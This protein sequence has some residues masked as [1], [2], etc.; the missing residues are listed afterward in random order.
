V[1]VLLD[2]QLLLWAAAKSRRIPK[3]ARQILESRANEIYF[4]AASIWEIA[5]KL[6][7]RRRDFDVDLER[8]RPALAEMEFLELPVTAAHAAGVVSLPAIHKDPFDRMLLAQG[9]AEAAR[10][11]T[12]DL[13]LARYG[14]AVLLV[15]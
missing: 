15:E 7:L 4:S 1:R 13:A 2:T 8:L 6:A 5:I 14:S 9:L 12:T 3:Q 10:L 11:I